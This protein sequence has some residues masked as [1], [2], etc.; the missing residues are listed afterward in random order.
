MTVKILVF[1]DVYGR[2]GRRM[3]AAHLPVLRE[4]YAPDFVVA[5]AENLTSGKG[6]SVRHADELLALGVDAMTGGNHSFSRLQEIAP[7][8]DAPGSRLIRP[9][10]FFRAPGFRVPGAGW[11]SLEKGGKRLFVLN[12]MSGLLMKDQMDNPFLAADRIL[13]ERAAGHDAVLV[14]FH[15]ET[16]SEIYC[17]AEF[18]DG[19]A[20]LVC[21]THTHVQTNDEHILAKGTGMI[22]DLGMTGPAHSA[23][24]QEFPARVA[25]MLTGTRLGG[26]KAVAVTEG[27]GA[28]HGIYAEIEGGK[29]VAIEKIRIRE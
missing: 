6:P 19:R 22:A 9:A 28:V 8:M 25:Q 1:G 17:M 15:R 5:N 2:V 7:Y 27:P 20:S 24:G 23:I 3:L 18:L 12:L 29:C 10:N 14:D 26:G 16:T 21:G 4:K 11:L 13:A